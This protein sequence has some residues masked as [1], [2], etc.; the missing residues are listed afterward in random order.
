MLFAS[1]EPYPRD[2]IRPFLLVPVF[3]AIY[4]VPPS[5]AQAMVGYGLG[6]GSAG[7][8]G[9]ALKR[10]GR[11]VSGRLSR[12]PSGEERPGFVGPRAG[13]AR[14][15]TEHELPVDFQHSTGV[16]RLFEL[17][18]GPQDVEPQSVEAKPLA[19]PARTAQTASTASPWGHRLLGATPEDLRRQFG[20]P[21]LA[22][23]GN[24][25]PEDG[26]YT[27]RLPD[28]G[29]ARFLVRSGVVVRAN[30]Y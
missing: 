15:S 22:V 10:S 8:S 20:K 17:W 7:A 21:I 27:H 13:S 1:N 6:V 18:S 30:R 24:G 11:A 12:L 28:G 3:V 29:K 9:G 2:V 23:S 19:P 16:V 25:G 4:A 14:R 26:Q 5:F